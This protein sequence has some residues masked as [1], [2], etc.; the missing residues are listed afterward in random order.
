MNTHF[1]RRQLSKRKESKQYEIQPI[2][3]ML[4]IRRKEL[5]LT[6]EEGAEGICSVSYLSKLENNLI[7]P[8]I[9]F[10]DQIMKRLGIVQ[11]ID[12]NQ[13]KYLRDLNQATKDMM[14]LTKRPSRL[15]SDYIDRDD[16]QA[17]LMHMID[18]NCI[19]DNALVLEHY[20]K[21]STFI[22]QFQQQEIVLC[23]LIL[24]ET[25]YRRHRFKDAYDVLVMSSKIKITKIDYHILIKRMKLIISFSMHKHID[26]EHEYM[27]YLHLVNE[28]SYYQLT[29]EMKKHHLI[30]RA[31]HQPTSSIMKL[32]ETDDPNQEL[33]Q[34][35]YAISLWVHQDYHKVI[36][37]SRPR[38][39]LSGWVFIYI[40]ALDILGDIQAITQ[41]IKRLEKENL[42]PSEK[43]IVDY[44]CLKHQTD[45][46]KRLFTLKRDLFYDDMC[47]DITILEY[48]VVDAAKQFSELQFYKDAYRILC[49]Y[50]L[51]FKLIKRSF[52]VYEEEEA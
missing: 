45:E 5:R 19:E 4:K 16:Y 26:I 41:L 30:Y 37:F 43:V 31:Y 38:K 35:P 33:E 48:I 39:R 42:T 6:L 29:N 20:E 23:L 40:T 27:S 44:M 1:L 22:P 17:H 34:L 47:D 8:N 18:A 9:E 15:A 51:K 11:T 13:D 21:C 32:S 49:E 36:E 24:C 52:D 46:E 28:Q 12:F 7:E 14:T 2:G 3:S 50:H 10:V 25:L